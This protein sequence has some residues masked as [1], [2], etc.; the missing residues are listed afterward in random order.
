MRFGAQTEVVMSL[1]MAQG[2]M[3]G[4]LVTQGWSGPSPSPSM[5]TQGLLGPL[6]LLQGLVGT[7]K[8]YVRTP[9]GGSVDGGMAAP[10]AHHGGSAS[11]G[12]KIG[13][14][15]RGFSRVKTLPAA[16]LSL[17]GS[18]RSKPRLSVICIGGLGI[19]G[20]ARWRSMLT[21]V[22]HGGVS[23]GGHNEST[24]INYHVYKNQGLGDAIN[25]AVPV[26]VVTSLNWTSGSLSVPGQYR[27]AVRTSDSLTGLEEQNVDAAVLLSLDSAGN[28]VTKVPFPPVGLRAFPKAGGTVRVEWIC[29]IG[30]P[31]RQPNGF[32]V[33]I[34]L[35]STIDYSKLATTV[36]WSSGRFGAFTT[37]QTGLKD[38]F[39]YSIG[40]RAYSAIGEESNTV[41]VTV[42]A[43]GTAPSLVDSLEAVAI[44]QE[45]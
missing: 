19:G 25:Y 32:H 30:D 17:G 42:K 34:T 5:I 23:M 27:F 8:T 35:G 38:G 37:D 11:G 18:A 26:G 4:G 14:S 6:V 44:N 21:T 41:A 3:G 12:L 40:V 22:A 9:S 7:H 15:G 16:G 36:P 45:S 20:S 13:A 39:I 10:Q 29:P 43:D 31:S 1:I 33:Y 2:L 28:D 24:G